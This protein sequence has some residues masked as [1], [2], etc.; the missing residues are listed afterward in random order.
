MKF[1]NLIL[2]I[3]ILFLSGCG[4]NIYSWELVQAEKICKEKGGISDINTFLRMDVT[5]NSGE[6]FYVDKK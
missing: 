4:K 5:C 3:T 6:T 1:K 2:I